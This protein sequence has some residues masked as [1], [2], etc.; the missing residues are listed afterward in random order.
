MSAP[1]PNEASRIRL[2]W[3][4]QAQFAGY[5]LAEHPDP[6][7]GRRAVLRT[8][9][10]V[11]GIGPL[12][13][14]F[15]GDAEFAVASPSHLLES[16]R[17]ADGVM[18]L[19]IQQASALV[20]PA[21][22]EHG[23]G[24]LEDLRGRRIAV[25]P[26]NEDLELRWM[27]QRAGVPPQAV[28]RVPMPDTVAP[29]RRGEVDCAQMTVYHELHEV[30]EGEGRC[31]DLV[32][33][34]AEQVGASL[35]KDGLFTTRR[36]ADRE[37][38]RVQQVVDAVL[39]GWARAFADPRGAVDACLLARPELRRDAQAHQLEVIRSLA[40]AGCAP[41]HGLGYPDP[42]HVERAAR[43]M[44]DLGHPVAVDPA[45]VVRAEFWRRAPR[46]PAPVA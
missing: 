6:E 32:L 28:A 35:L 14:L 34:R 4:P 17:A 12:E 5:L 24:C 43:A 26:G 19:T 37:P 29:F 10:M 25:W 40:G 20:Y 46:Y 38:E 13:A 18:L 41:E 7:G 15:S 45:R 33:F 27:L 23:I 16:S 8:S 9:A 2:L 31:D 21:H 3:H 11:P 30:T 36:L 39:H 44:T 1:G 42:A 22:R